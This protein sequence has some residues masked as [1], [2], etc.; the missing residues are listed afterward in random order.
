MA[1]TT[2]SNV[3]LRAG[4]GSSFI[5]TVEPLVLLSPPLTTLV[6]TS[7]SDGGSADG[8]FRHPSVKTT[9]RPTPVRRAP[10]AANRVMATYKS[11]LGRG[12]ASPLS[13]RRSR[14]G[15]KRDVRRRHDL[16][17]TWTRKTGEHLEVHPGRPWDRRNPAVTLHCSRPYP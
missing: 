4:A 17:R 8:T 2:R 10:Q 11:S 15:R 1:S 5:A 7:E 9:V 13:T 14:G 16:S 6:A 12:P 3:D